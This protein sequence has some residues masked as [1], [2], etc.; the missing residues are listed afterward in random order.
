MRILFI[1]LLLLFSR[2]CDCEKHYEIIRE[3]NI[4]VVGRYLIAC[5]S[6]N[7]D[8]GGKTLRKGL[9]T[10]Y[11]CIGRI[12]AMLLKLGSHWL[13]KVAPRCAMLNKQ[14]RTVQNCAFKL[15]KIVVRQCANQLPFL[16]T[17]MEN[18]KMGDHALNICQFPF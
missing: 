12:R 3:Y 4:F 1:I 11:V 7:G 8:L 15:K 18:V 2:C 5:Q 16:R 14:H 13:H 6:D 9:L 10:Y 17:N